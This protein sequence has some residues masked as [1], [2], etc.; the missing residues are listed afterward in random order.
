MDKKTG[1]YSESEKAHI[2]Q[3]IADILITP[4]GS[5]IQ[6]REYGSFIFELIDRPMS[7]ML[8]LQI[9]VAALIAIK[10]WEP[11]VEVIRF[12]VN[13]EPKNGQITADI[14]MVHKQDKQKMTINDL[15][16]KGN[17]ERIS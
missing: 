1:R 2:R 3:S 9:S 13:P 8:T 10:R 5:R 11:R 16:L 12:A 7:A 6:R 17:N 15:I 4:I 14:E